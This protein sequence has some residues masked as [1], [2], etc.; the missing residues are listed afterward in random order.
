MK[1]GPPAILPIL[2]SDTVGELLAR[3]LLHPERGYTLT[4]LSTDLGVSLPTIG[5]EIDRMLTA[6]LLVQERVGR[7]RRVSANSASVLFQPLSE[8]IALTFGPRPV[9]E[10][11]L[12]GVDRVDGAMIYGSWA[13]RYL[14]E[15]GAEP[16][17]VDVLVIGT[18]DPDVLFDVAESG[19]HRLK[20]DVTIR[21]VPSKTWHREDLH[22]PFLRHVKSRPIV[23]LCLGGQS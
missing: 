12:A 11:L 8:I 1:V 16:N 23:S 2:R 21:A 3:L 15:A 5:R 6:G 13:A 20:R 18:P 7:A 9:L 22:D 17:D 14:G 10:E 4:E 19:R